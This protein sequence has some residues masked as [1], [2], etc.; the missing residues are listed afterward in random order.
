MK[1]MPNLKMA[2]DVPQNLGKDIRQ[3]KYSPK[4]ERLQTRLDRSPTASSKPEMVARTLLKNRKGGEK[5]SRRLQ[6]ERGSERE[7]K[8]PKK[9]GRGRRR[10]SSR[11][12][13]MSLRIIIPMIRRRMVRVNLKMQTWLRALILPAKVCLWYNLPIRRV[14]HPHPL[15]S[16]RSYLLNRIP[17]LRQYRL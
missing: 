1:K 7:R 5:R 3:T 15:S 12:W 13:P 17:R 2:E 14:H 6:N 8:K 16:H 9:R 4:R 11:L 10:G